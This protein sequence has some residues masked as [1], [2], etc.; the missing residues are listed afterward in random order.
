V[1]R[2]PCPSG[3]AGT[4]LSLTVPQRARLT[5]KVGQG[6]RNQEAIINVKLLTLFAKMAHEPCQ[7]I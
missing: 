4:S 5:E 3:Q 6:M 1:K 7:I 2:L